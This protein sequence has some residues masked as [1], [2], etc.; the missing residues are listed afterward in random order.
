MRL[1]RFLGTTIAH[2]TDPVY[3]T[4]W[5]CPFTRRLGRSLAYHLFP[6]PWEWQSSKFTEPYFCIGHRTKGVI[7]ANQNLS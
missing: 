7:K 3:T 2:S 6:G 4:H 1:A 5:A